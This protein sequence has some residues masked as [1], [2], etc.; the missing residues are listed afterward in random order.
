MNFLTTKHRKKNFGD[1]G[2][3]FVRL[4][5]ATLALLI[6]VFTAACG[7]SGASSQP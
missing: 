5:C 7:K 1:T 4:F 6:S 2:D 3:T